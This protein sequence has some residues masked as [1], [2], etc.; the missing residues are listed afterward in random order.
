MIIMMRVKCLALGTICLFTTFRAEQFCSHDEFPLCQSSMGVRI[1]RRGNGGVSGKPLPPLRQVPLCLFICNNQ[2]V[3]QIVSSLGCC[4]NTALQVGREQKHLE[5]RGRE[6]IFVMTP[7]LYRFF[8]LLL[9]FYSVV[10]VIADFC[11]HQKARPLFIYLVCMRFIFG[12][13]DHQSWH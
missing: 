6:I 2:M 8:P 11:K 12:L 10:K 1:R 9:S 3:F 7:C 4:I 5:L 13:G